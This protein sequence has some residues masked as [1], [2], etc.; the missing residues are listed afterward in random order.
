[1]NIRSKN[2]NIHSNNNDK[3]ARNS[4]GWL[5]A[6]G[7]TFIDPTHEIEQKT[8]MSTQICYS[9]LSSIHIMMVWCH[10]SVQ[11]VYSKV[12]FKIPTLKKLQHPWQLT[13]KLD[14]K[15]PTFD[16]HSTSYFAI[17]FSWRSTPFEFTC[18][19]SVSAVCQLPYICAQQYIDKYKKIAL[20]IKDCWC[21]FH[22]PTCLFNVIWNQI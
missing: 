19:A 15:L 10:N 13:I 2:M 12:S 21:M 16:I 4:P 14:K 17:S 1:M 6:Q 8:S 3:T 11:H 20:L 9:F 5:Y 22:S 7:A 18:F